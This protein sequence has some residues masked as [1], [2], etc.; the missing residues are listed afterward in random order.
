MDRDIHQCCCIGPQNGDPVCPCQ[1]AEY[2]QRE[3]DR[4]A[5]EWVKK[6]FGKKGK[7]K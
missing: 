6:F 1:M 7:K 5:W 3:S 4:R 2:S